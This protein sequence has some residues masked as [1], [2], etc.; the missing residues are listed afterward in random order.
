MGGRMNFPEAP[1]GHPVMVDSI[2]SQVGYLACLPHSREIKYNALSDRACLR[3]ESPCLKV[4]RTRPVL[5]QTQ[6]T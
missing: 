6:A 4:A 2:T 3:P 1:N 5:F